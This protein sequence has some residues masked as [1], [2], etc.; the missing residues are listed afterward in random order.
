MAHVL[1]HV[2]AETAAEHERQHQADAN[3]DRIG[4][5]APRAQDHDAHPQTH[6]NHRHRAEAHQAVHR[7]IERRCEIEM[8]CFAAARLFDDVENLERRADDRDHRHPTSF[9]RLDEAVGQQR[10]E[11]RKRRKIH[12]D[13]QRKLERLRPHGYAVERTFVERAEHAADDRQRGE[14]ERR[15]PPQRMTAI[16]GTHL[17]RRRQRPRLHR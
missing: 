17:R 9:A 11:P 8:R 16:Q 15:A 6:G 3:R 7:R 13:R 5:A 14:N 12:C 4:V 10:H 2:S 1:P